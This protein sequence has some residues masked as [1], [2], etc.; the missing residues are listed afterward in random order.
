[1]KDATV[2]WVRS[3]A[4]EPPQVS[5][6]AR[7]KN[8]S[9]MAPETNKNQNMCQTVTSGNW[10]LLTFR[11]LEIPAML[12][13]YGCF[14]Y[15]CVFFRAT[16]V[17]YGSFQARGPVELQLAAYATATATQDP[18]CIC[19]LYHGSWQCRILN[20]LSEARD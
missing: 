2:V 8:Y 5:S 18:S 19:N 6:E 12:F 7:T 17:A 14:I 16:R 10:G 4:W 1:M 20:P 13:I 9:F 11:V 3:L 15:L